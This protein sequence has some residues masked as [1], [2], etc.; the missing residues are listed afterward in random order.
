MIEDAIITCYRRGADPKAV[1]LWYKLNQGTRIRVRTGAGLSE[2]CQAGALVGQGTL[3]GELVSQGVLDQEISG[4]F[5]PWGGGQDDLWRGAT[6][7]TNLHGR[8]FY[9][10][11][12]E[13]KR[14][15]SRI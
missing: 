4:L 1:R 8:C 11:P 2:Y 13:L 7:A 15:G 6:I 10:V 12:R 9:T 5:A 3:G 14:P